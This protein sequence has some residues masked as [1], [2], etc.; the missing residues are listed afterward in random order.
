MVSVRVD[1]EPDRGGQ[2]GRLRLLYLVGG[3]QVGGT[4]RHLS[5]LL[6]RLDETKWDLR[7]RLLGEDGPLS[8]PLRE[9]GIDVQG[10][11]ATPS[12][13]IPKLR[14]LARLVVLARRI[15]REMVKVEPRIIHCWLPEPCILGWLARRFAGINC[16]LVMSRRSQDVRPQ[17]FPGEKWLEH[18]ALRAADHVLGNSRAVFEE[19][20]LLGV[21]PQRLHLIRNGVDFDR[22]SRTPS[23]EQVRA[24]QGWPDELVVIV[25]VA[26]LIP[27]KDHRTLLRALGALDGAQ[28]PWRLLLMGG[29]ESQYEA[30]LNLLARD[31]GIHDRVEFRGRSDTIL[32]LL[33][34]CDMGVL[35]SHHEGFS[36]A[37]IEYMA[38]GLP[39]VATDVGGNRDAVKDGHNGFLVPPSQL[40][41]LC[42]GLTRLLDDRELRHRLGAAG[43]QR[44]R[45]EFSIERCVEDYQA[46]YLSA[47][48]E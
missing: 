33:S 43:Q 32:E 11:G 17:S 36:N 8:A 28:P 35:T 30:G 34:G 44:A 5:L 38:C 48:N 15:A 29:G 6:P 18:K 25:C 10:L 27:Y 4:E 22:L 12:L 45:A 23:R 46:F 21:E 14:G 13:P 9:A 16:S 39:V 2:P 40:E 24:A 42:H 7:V 1:P 20:N 41:P 26:N 37:L 31:L 47:L 3:F 19:L